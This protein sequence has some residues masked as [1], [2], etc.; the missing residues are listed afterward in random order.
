MPL[1]DKELR[2]LVSLAK[3]AL[4]AGRDTHAYLQAAG[5]HVSPANFYA[6]IPSVADVDASFEYAEQRDGRAPYADTFDADRVRAF[7]GMLEAFAHEFDPPMEGDRD[8]PAGFFWGNPA[9]S[10][11]DAMA[12]YCV[13]RATRPERVFEI[14][15][16][17]SSLVAD[18][19]LRRN[20]RGELWVLEPYPKPFLRRLETL[21]RIIERPVQ[22]LPAAEVVSLVEQSDLWF[23]DSTHTVKAGSD[24]L[25]IYLKVMPAIRKRMLCHSHD[26]YLPYAM[27]PRLALEKQIFWTEQYLLQ[28]FL[29]GNPAA[30]ILFGSYYLHHQHPALASA[31]MQGRHEPGGASLWY[32]LN[33]AAGA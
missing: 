16:G 7:A 11:L 1:N 27:P 30:R 20:G 3:K 24:C 28:A 18:L 26:I 15:A 29:L 17:F 9:F 5:V 32:E 2:T 25:F 31:L 4:W 12:Y 6:T 21:G 8:D 23:I 13:L 10:R 33:P 22:A 14:G 19:A